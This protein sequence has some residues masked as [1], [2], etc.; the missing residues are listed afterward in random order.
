MIATSPVPIIQK[1]FDEIFVKKD[2]FM[3]KVIPLALVVLYLVKGSFSY[4]QNVII[5][6]IS[7]ELVVSLREKIFI[8]VQRLPL[9]FFE[10]TTSGEIISRINNDVS[11]MQSSIT[12][13]V[14]EFFQN[15]IMLIGL[16]CWV[17]YLK[18][19][20]ALM[21]LA[22]LPLAAIPIG[23][24]AR[25]LR[26][27]TR[28][29]Q[30]TLAH[31]N[32]T[33]HETLGGIK[34]V[35]AFSLE[36]RQVKKLARQNDEYL[37]IMKKNVKYTEIPSPLM[38]VVG[39]SSGAMVL[40]SGGQQVLT[41]QVSQGSFIAFIVA[42]FMMY[43]PIR[44]I[45]KI[46]TKFQ[47]AL[48]AAERVFYILD[49]EEENTFR[50]DG[51]KL[52]EFQNSIEFDNVSF[53]YPSRPAWVLKNIKLRVEKS[54]VVAIVGMSGAGKTTLIDLLFR[55]FDAS[56]GTVRID[57]KD[58]REFDL[59]SLRNQ[60]ALVTQETF[61]FN[62]TIRNN[63]AFGKNGALEGEIIQAAKAANVHNFV[64]TMEDGYNSM[65]G[66][67]GVKL[68]GGQKQRLSIARAI[69]KNAPILVLDEAT[70][71]LDSESEK[72]VQNALK[73]LMKNRTTFVIAHRLSTIKSAERII[74]LDDGE[75]VQ[76]GTHSQL[77]ANSGIY[78]KYYELQFM[79]NSP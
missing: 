76:E 28:R 16:I 12:N 54:E 71:S 53:R 37:I 44:L 13:M 68:S 75:I 47:G 74:V 9:A 43:G 34:V 32:S 66:E 31:I 22:I 78:Q 48:A 41:N 6:G 69:L 18:W 59:K 7:W 65:I 14:K 60:L 64:Q 33:I 36:D 42:L 73:H 55:Y 26:N 29:G 8:K 35:R 23:N 40:W 24:I 63:I 4:L 56:Q 72:L 11:V 10:A 21:A 51:I 58:I 46:Y 5:F 19:D 61:L 30:E 57:D 62:D 3:L 67:R 39:M 17:F 1:T 49:Q 77:L 79:G 45:F 52:P 70:S 2:F 38:E 25:K 50:T 27:L 20:W 15:V